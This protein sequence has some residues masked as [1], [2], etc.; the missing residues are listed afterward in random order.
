MQ[1][2]GT[3]WIKAPWLETG[4]STLTYAQAG[5]Q[6]GLYLLNFND[7]GVETLSEQLT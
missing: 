7:L 5:G 2:N 4:Q 3:T 6:Q 1:A